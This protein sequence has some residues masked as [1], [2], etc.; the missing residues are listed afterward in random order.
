MVSDGF[1]VLHYFTAFPPGYPPNDHAILIHWP[2]GQCVIDTLARETKHDFDHA[3]NP[4]DRISNR[5]F[6]YRS[7]IFS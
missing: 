4:S 7:V 2:A 3:L 5:V 6:T 1:Q